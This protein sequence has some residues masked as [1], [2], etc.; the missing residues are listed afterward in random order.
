[1][2]RLHSTLQTANLYLVAKFLSIFAF[3]TWI[4]PHNVVINQLFGG[5]TGLSLIPITFDVSYA[6]D[7]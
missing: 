7:I 6:Q 4:R 1:M 5:S 3:I 2:S